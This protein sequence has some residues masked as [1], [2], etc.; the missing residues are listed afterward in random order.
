MKK[1]RLGFTA[2]SEMQWSIL[3]G[4]AEAVRTLALASRED[5]VIPRE[6]ES[7]I[8]A[9]VND[10]VPRLKPQAAELL[11]RVDLKGESVKNAAR[12]VGVTVANASVILF[13]ARKELRKQL[14]AFCGECAS[15]GCLDCHCG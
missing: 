5:V 8:C 2:S 10:L 11:R 9:C 1:S 15:G 14:E 6:W 12:S 13:R 4:G 3:I 7:Q